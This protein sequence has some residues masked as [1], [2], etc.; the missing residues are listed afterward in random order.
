MILYDY[1][2]LLLLTG[3]S[4]QQVDTGSLCPSVGYISK[5]TKW[6]RGFRQVDS[7]RQIDSVCANCEQFQ[8]VRL[9]LKQKSKLS[10]RKVHSGGPPTALSLG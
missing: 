7:C 1:H 6:I 4:L 10:F 5:I 9:S 3:Q 2:K 8:P